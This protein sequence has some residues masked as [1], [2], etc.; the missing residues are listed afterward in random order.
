MI[1]NSV[2]VL[3]SAVWLLIVLVAFSGHGQNATAFSGLSEFQARTHMTK[4]RYSKVIFE[5]RRTRYIQ[6][7]PDSLIAREM[8]ALQRGRGSDGVSDWLI[9]VTEITAWPQTKERE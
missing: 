4:P 8:A 2:R 7:H 1:R 6:N 3:A 9:P 5:E